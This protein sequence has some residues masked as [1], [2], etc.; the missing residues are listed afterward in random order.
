MVDT[1]DNIE[2]VNDSELDGL[3]AKWAFRS[4]IEEIITQVSKTEW[5]E[6]AEDGIGLLE[7][8]A[9]EGYIT[10]R[11]FEAASGSIGRYLQLAK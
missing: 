6:T 11:E 10:T 7:Y 1:Q 5:V 9:D 4:R 3:R 8:M 2:D